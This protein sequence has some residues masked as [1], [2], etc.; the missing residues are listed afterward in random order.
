MNLARLAKLKSSLCSMFKM[1][2]MK[3]TTTCIGI[4]IT[5]TDDGIELDQAN[6]VKEI[7]HRFNMS[8]YNPI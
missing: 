8:D 2:D 7:L 5:Q 6:Y 3:T 1:K 4:R